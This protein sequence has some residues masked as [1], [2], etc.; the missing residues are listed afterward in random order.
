[1]IVQ[2][3]RGL[4]MEPAQQAW[5]S[6]QFISKRLC[7]RECQRIALA[8]VSTTRADLHNQTSA[9]TLEE[10]VR[11]SCGKVAVRGRVPIDRRACCSMHRIAAEMHLSDSELCL[12]SLRL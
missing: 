1:M 9:A 4:L 12:E 2:A 3:V 10:G 6:K 7:L 8:F 11:A 5:G